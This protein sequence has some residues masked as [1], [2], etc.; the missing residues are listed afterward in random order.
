MLRSLLELDGEI[1]HTQAWGRVPGLVF[2]ERRRV[3]FDDPFEMRSGMIGA[4]SSPAVHHGTL[5]LLPAYTGCTSLDEAL[6][7]SR[8]QTIL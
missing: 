8:N 5:K 7:D 4:M 1:Y 3:R 6:A 2:D